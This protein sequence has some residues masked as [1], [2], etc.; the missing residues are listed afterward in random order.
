MLETMKSL[1]SSAVLLSAALALSA[2]AAEEDGTADSPAD[3][4]AS[5][6]A[7][8]EARELKEFVGTAWRVS[9]EDGAR[10]V[11]Y[12]D[13]E[14]RYRDLRNG[15]PWQEGGWSLEA[16]PG[17]EEGQVLLCFQPEGDNV[18][19][20][21]W[22]TGKLDDGKLVVTSGGGRRV[23]LEKVAYEAPQDAETAE[24]AQ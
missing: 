13:A 6:G 20:R 2:C 21:C 3:V 11:T 16:A 1:V 10:Y 12:L 7:A 9:A 18:R 19:E 22:E 23:Q 8:D 17:D 4:A 24:A 14:G 15:D 5:T